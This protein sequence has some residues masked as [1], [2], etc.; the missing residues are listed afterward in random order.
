M[1]LNIPCWV[2]TSILHTT[3]CSDN[4]LKL[5]NGVFSLCPVLPGMVQEDYHSQ[6]PYHNAVHAADV[7]Q[8]MYC[9]L[10]EPK[11]MNHTVFTHT[12]THRFLLSHTTYKA[13]LAL[14]FSL[15]DPISVS[16]WRIIPSHFDTT[17]RPS[18]AH[19][20]FDQIRCLRI[21][22]LYTVIAF[23]SSVAL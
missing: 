20:P 18:T 8:A 21:F 16:C 12:L 22:S 7:T 14:S 15:T 17:T 13:S 3:V 23:V 1:L 19:T 5:F 4:Q 2:T 11:V 10:K 6:N 9:Y